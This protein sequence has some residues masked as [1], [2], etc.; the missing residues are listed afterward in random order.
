M[1]NA[2]NYD[3][4]GGSPEEADANESMARSMRKSRERAEVSRARADIAEARKCLRRNSSPSNQA[5]L[6]QAEERLINAVAAL[7]G[8]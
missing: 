2:M 6:A 4:C 5:A 7:K 1:R 8:P 3:R